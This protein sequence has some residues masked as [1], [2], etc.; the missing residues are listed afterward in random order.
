MRI[1]SI[2]VALLLGVGVAVAR[3]PLYVVNGRVVASI[4]DIPH[5]DIERIDVLPANEDTIAEW[6]SE[7]SEGVIIVTLRYDTAATFVAE[8]YDNFTD[9]LAHTVKWSDNN[10]AER[11]SLRL[12]IE[13]SGRATI[14]EVLQATSRNYLKRVERA[15]EEA[16]LW[17]PAMRDGVA[18]ESI[19]LVNLQLPEGK[20]IPLEPAVIIR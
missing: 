12:H 5:E 11:V 4:E 20:S 18:V 17:S 14:S 7:A 6:G 15:I 2:V 19:Q 13:A 3:E 9:Y 8:G 1:I 16:P 10:P